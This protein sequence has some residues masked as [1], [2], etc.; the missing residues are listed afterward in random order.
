MNKLLIGTA[1]GTVMLTSCFAAEAQ[2]SDMES[3]VNQLE[4]KI[5]KLERLLE[6]KDQKKSNGEVKTKKSE[7]ASYSGPVKIS[8]KPAPKF[9]TADGSFKFGIG[10]FLQEDAAWFSDDISDHPDGFNLRRARVSVEGTIFDDWAYKFENDF[11]NNQ[12]RITDAFISYSGA[13]PVKITA[14][15]FKEPFSLETLTSDK[16]TTFIERASLAAFAPDRNIGVAALIDGLNWS[17]TGGFFRNNTGSTAT[18]DQQ[19]S[20]TARTHYAPIAEEDK[21]VHLGLAFSTVCLKNL[22]NL[23]SMSQKPKHLCKVCAL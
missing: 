8:L 9:E 5:A 16:Y 23:S 6:E 17:L 18:D 13:K 15:Q 11:A 22:Q 4:E 19:Y 20:F 2:Q 7:S 3:K 1:I 21:S 14:G 10:G 12:S